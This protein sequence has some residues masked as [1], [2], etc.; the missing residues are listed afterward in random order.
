M[1]T[2]TVEEGSEEIKKSAEQDS[3]LSAVKP[4]KTVEK[5]EK[6]MKEVIKDEGKSRKRSAEESDDMPEDESDSKKQKLDKYQVYCGNI[7]KGTDK[8][9]LYF[10]IGENNVFPEIRMVKMQTQKGRGK[11]RKRHTRVHHAILTCKTLEDAEKVVS[12]NGI[13]MPAPLGRGESRLAIH[14]IRQDETDACKLYLGNLSEDTDEDDLKVFFKDHNLRPYRIIVIRRKRQMISK[15][16]GFVW[17]DTT[18]D[19]D[20]ALQLNGASVQD[21]EICIE[22]LKKTEKVD[23]EE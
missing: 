9:M 18:S 17:F 23:E 7:P 14:H 6:E 4:E 21:Q 12:L 1:T 3:E 11:A 16:Y 22:H 15:G 13:S 8:E 10:F 5:I 20:K 19:A 2:L